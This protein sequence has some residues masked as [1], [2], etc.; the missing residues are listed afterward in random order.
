MMDVMSKTVQGRQTP[1]NIFSTTQNLLITTN[2]NESNRGRILSEE[3]VFQLISN[4]IRL[5]TSSFHNVR[6]SI[7]NRVL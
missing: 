2:K 1:G 3:G 7:L 5:R 4:N 6:N